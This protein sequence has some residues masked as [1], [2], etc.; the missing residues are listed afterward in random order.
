MH[1]IS[2]ER[3]PSASEGEHSLLCASLERPPS[4]LFA[5]GG[6]H[7]CA[8]NISPR[9][10]LFSSPCTEGAQALSRELIAF[11]EEMQRRSLLFRRRRT[12]SPKAL[13][14]PKALYRASGSHLCAPNLSPRDRLRRRRSLRRRRTLSPKAFSSLSPKAF[15]RASKHK[16]YSA[17]AFA[18]GER[19]EKRR[20]SR[21]REEKRSAESL[22]EEKGTV[23]RYLKKWLKKS[24]ERFGD[25]L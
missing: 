8:P 11:G 18:K 6:S 12:L 13:S 24:R 4:H 20:V 14:S 25:F 21:R 5:E 15:S 9:D 19:E 10:R 22:G 23:T 3:A 16:R 17:Q 7:L 2:L 1:R